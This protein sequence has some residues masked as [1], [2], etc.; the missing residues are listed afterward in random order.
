MPPHLCQTC[1]QNPAT[2]HFTEIRNE[3]KRELHVCEACAESQ[4]IAARPRD[5]QPPDDARPPGQGRCKRP[6]RT[7][8]P[9][10]PDVRHLLRRVPREG[11]ARLPERLRV[12]RGALTPLLEKIHGS[13]EHRAAC[14][15]GSLDAAGSAND[16]LLR[17]RRELQEAVEGEQYEE[18]ARL[19]DEIRRVEEG[20]LTG[21]VAGG[22]KPPAPRERKRRSAS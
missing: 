14:P 19:R 7:P 12:L 13:S 10:C 20:T 22:A 18:A 3:E 9:R 21:P 8:A 4:G 16:R 5:G 17:L 1:K 6:P 2:I 15:A 11:P